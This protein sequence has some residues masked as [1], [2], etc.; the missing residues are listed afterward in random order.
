VSLRDQIFAVEDIRKEIVEI[1][2]WGGIKIEV[3][4]LTGGDRARIL[5]TGVD[6]HGNVSLQRVYPEM[7]IAS[8]FDPE[9]GERIFEEADKDGLMA[10]NALAIDRLATVATKLS[11]LNDEA[12]EE[13]GKNSSSTRKGGSTSS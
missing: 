6:A 5:E 4:S 9:S 2:E 7:V 13:A 11:G 1:P 3:R 12:V 8:A 10:K